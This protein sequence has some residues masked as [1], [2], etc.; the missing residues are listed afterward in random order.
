MTELSLYGACASSRLPR[1]RARVWAPNRRKKVPTPDV[2]D[3]TE[4]VLEQIAEEYDMIIETMEVSL[5]HVCMC[6]DAPLVCHWLG[7]CRF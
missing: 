6:H 1:D 2:A 7:S 5:G 3:D 4:M